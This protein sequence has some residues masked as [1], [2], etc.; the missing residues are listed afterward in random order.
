LTA[1]RC[2]CLMAPSFP[3][4]YLRISTDWLCA[5]SLNSVILSSALTSTD[6]IN[7]SIDIAPPTPVKA[8]LGPVQLFPILH[9]PQYVPGSTKRPI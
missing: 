2:F 3:S 9:V 7:C 8:F 6:S 5:F 1:S 4:A